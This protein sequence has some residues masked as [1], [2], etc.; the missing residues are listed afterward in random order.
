MTRA[1]PLSPSVTPGFALEGPR[2]IGSDPTTVEASRLR[3]GHKPAHGAVEA[4]GI[5]RHAP[6]QRLSAGHGLRVAPGVRGQLIAAI[7]QAP[8]AG[9][10]FPLAKRAAR[11]RL[12]QMPRD[13]IPWDVVSRW[14]RSLQHAYAARAASNLHCAPDDAHLARLR[15]QARWPREVP[16]RG[17]ARARLRSEARP[18]LP[19]P[20]PLFARGLQ[21]GRWPAGSHKALF[22]AEGVA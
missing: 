2:Q 6:S 13:V 11:R 12:E 15:C 8:V 16:D 19:T 14:M 1:Y 5:E 18:C 21:P 3:G 7:D 10:A 17:L 9:R 22:T 20:A 4:V